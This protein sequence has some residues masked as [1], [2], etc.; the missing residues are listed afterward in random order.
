MSADKALLPVTSARALSLSHQVHTNKT[1]MSKWHRLAYL[2]C[3]GLGP[4]PAGH[5][6]MR[7]VT[8]IEAPQLGAAPLHDVIWQL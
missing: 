5:P 6:N 3:I 7:W 4:L 2:E 1:D 8:V